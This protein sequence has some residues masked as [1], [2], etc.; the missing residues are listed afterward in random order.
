MQK[1]LMYEIWWVWTPFHTWEAMIPLIYKV[2]EEIKLTE[3]PEVLRHQCGANAFFAHIKTVVL[4]NTTRWQKKT[5]YL[6]EGT[7][8]KI[9]ESEYLMRPAHLPG[10]YRELGS[11]VTS[12]H[13]YASPP[14]LYL[15]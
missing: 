6:I 10:E 1:Y 5:M 3:V 7:C 2:P 4:K 14:N 12:A 9:L 8:S 15:S 13:S 11:L